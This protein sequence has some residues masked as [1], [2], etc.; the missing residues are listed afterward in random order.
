MSEFFNIRRRLSFFVLLLLILFAFS[1]ASSGYWIHWAFLA[2]AWGFFMI[3]DFL[4][5][6]ENTFV[7]DPSYKGWA[8]RTASY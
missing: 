6:A 2:F 3:V 5:L 1:A 8:I 4:F 7:Y